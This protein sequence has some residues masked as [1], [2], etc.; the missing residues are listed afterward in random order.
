MGRALGIGVVCLGSACALGDDGGLLDASVVAME[1]QQSVSV[2]ATADSGVRKLAPDQR[3]GYEPTLDVRADAARA[4]VRFDTSAV[5]SSGVVEPISSAA[6]NLSITRTTL[7]D[8]SNRALAL[9]RL[10]L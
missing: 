6:V 3:F 4:L 1:T 8:P 5:V 10:E 2:E 7:G 9:H